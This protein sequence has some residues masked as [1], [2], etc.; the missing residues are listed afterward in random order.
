MDLLKFCAGLDG[1]ERFRRPWVHEEHSYATDGSI[2]VRVP[3]RE[4]DREIE[5]CIPQ[6]AKLSFDHAL[7]P[8]ALWLPVDG[9]LQGAQREVTQA[10]RHLLA[11]HQVRALA[12]LPE[13]RI[14][15]EASLPHTP[16]RFK[17]AGGL[18]L[19]MPLMDGV[20]R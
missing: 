10:G 1:Q 15:P 3:R 13:A 8:P 2:V 12:E 7:V 17:F 14:A 4:E 16:V 18:G 6:L 9:L 5:G 20:K 11:T 19:V